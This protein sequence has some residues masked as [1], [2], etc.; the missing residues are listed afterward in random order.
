MA[1]APRGFKALGEDKAGSPKKKEK[2]RGRTDAKGI[3]AAIA[4]I[5]ADYALILVG[6][7]AVVLRET[8]DFRARPDIGLLT[9]DAFKAWFLPEKYEV[10]GEFVS[11]GPL[12]LNSQ[13]RR[14][15]H[16]ICFVP[17][18]VKGYQGPHRVP[19]GWYNLWRGYSVE[20]DASPEAA[21]LIQGYLD[22][23]RENVANGNEEHFRWIIGWFAHMFQ[24]PQD[25]LGVSLVLQGEQ[26]SGKTI[27]GKIAG[28]LLRTHYLLVTKPKHLT[29]DFNAYM[30]SCLLLQAEESFWAGD[31]AAEGTLKDLITGDQHLIEGKGVDAIPVLNLIRLLITSNN[32]WVVPAA[33]EERRHGVFRVGN[34]RQQQRTY[35][36]AIE[37]DMEAGG[38]GALL[39]YFLTF[40]LA[41]V[42]LGAVP[43]TEAL[44]E[45]KIES[46]NTEQAFWY[47]VLERGSPFKNSARWPVEIGKEKLF[48]EYLAYA[49]QIGQRRRGAQTKFWKQVR[50][51][52]PDLREEKPWRELTDADGNTIYEKGKPVLRRYRLIVLP[53]LQECRD[54]FDKRAGQ[55]VPWPPID[56]NKPPNE[57]APAAQ[58]PPSSPPPALPPPPAVSPLQ[59]DPL[60]DPDA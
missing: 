2:K 14:D 37:R 4:T 51:L 19:D 22:H 33:L 31:K 57:A 25:R 5:N 21:K 29:G 48:S 8:V 49:D 44:L 47:E 50:K 26:G 1:D 28:H 45:Q 24:R 39:H 6:A 54:A 17:E 40:D 13:H 52:C 60:Y 27:V 46:L 56:D 32:D 41:S 3:Q 18:G 35:F 53:K 34:K 59:G 38:Y 10:N 30:K 20:P 55:P 42:N 16:G 43:K 58:A 9:I 15:L 7:K 12:W 23:I 11:I 36:E